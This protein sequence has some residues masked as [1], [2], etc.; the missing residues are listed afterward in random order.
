[1][2]LIEAF[3]QI[4]LADPRFPPRLGESPDKLSI[5]VRMKRSDGLPMLLSL[6]GFIWLHGALGRAL[7]VPMLNSDIYGVFDV[8]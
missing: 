8:A 6:V 2:R 7:P 5:L 4:L 3:R 1:M